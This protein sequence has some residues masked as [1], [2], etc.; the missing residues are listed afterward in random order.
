MADLDAD[1]GKTVE[2]IFGDGRG[3]HGG[4]QERTKG[5]ENLNQEVKHGF[6]Y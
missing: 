6:I 5:M 1:L 4:G 2:E 3:G